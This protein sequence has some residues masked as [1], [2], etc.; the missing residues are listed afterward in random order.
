MRREPEHI[1][2]AR[3]TARR[4]RAD[5]TSPDQYANDQ[6][7]DAYESPTNG[8]IPT[9]PWEPPIPLVETPEAEPFPLDVLPQQLAHFSE[10][11]SLAK[12]CP[13]DYVAVPLLTIAGAAIGASRVL[14]IK[15]GWR[16]RPCL[17]AAVIGPPGSAKTPALTRKRTLTAKAS[18][19]LPSLSPTFA[20]IALKF[21]PSSGPIRKWKTLVACWIGSGAN[22]QSR[23]NVT[24]S[25]RM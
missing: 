1:R 7:G 8:E 14:E 24:M 12:H 9:E 18:N 17:Y 23:S 11:V 5:G 6:R 4:H 21:T 16:E 19:E 10:A 20:H 3:E 15:P 22:G 13:P 25:S 2:R